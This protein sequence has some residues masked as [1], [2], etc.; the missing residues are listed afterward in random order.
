MSALVKLNLKTVKRV[1]EV[2]PVTARRERLVAGIDEQLA[3]LAAQLAGKTHTVAVVRKLTGA[4]GVRQAVTVQKAVRAWYFEQDA[5]Y[6]VQ[7]RYGTRVLILHGKSNA[8]FVDK[9]AQVAEVLGVFRAAALTGEFD[10]A[11][12]LVMRARSKQGE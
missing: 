8:V 3:A 2:D 10:R 7:C 4:D 1:T 6:Y 5:G 9:L 12:L 11:V